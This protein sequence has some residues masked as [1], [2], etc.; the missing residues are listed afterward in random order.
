[1]HRL[2]RG[3][4]T[5][6]CG[7][8]GRE[9]GTIAWKQIERLLD[10]GAVVLCLI[11]YLRQC[12]LRR[13]DRRQDGLAMRRIAL[14]KEFLSNVLQ[15]QN[16]R[17]QAHGLGRGGK[18]LAD[19]LARGAAPVRY[20]GENFRLTFGDRFRKRLHLASGAIERSLGPGDIGPVVDRLDEGAEM[21]PIVLHARKERFDPVALVAERRG[22]FAQG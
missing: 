14:L 3:G 2:E 18:G 19:L 21:S 16:R 17:S 10:D 11:R 7:L 20:V 1:M 5:K 8:G 22:R 13:G 9:S 4:L 6:T 12:F 15:M